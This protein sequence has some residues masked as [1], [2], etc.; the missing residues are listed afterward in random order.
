MPTQ[1][2]PSH[3]SGTLCRRILN[4]REFFDM[5][6]D[7]VASQLWTQHTDPQAKGRGKGTKGGGEGVLHPTTQL[8]PQLNT[9]RS[10][11]I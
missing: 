2:E 11:Q 5:E 8:E 3:S 4:I 9:G 10:V 6:R 1:T 7:P